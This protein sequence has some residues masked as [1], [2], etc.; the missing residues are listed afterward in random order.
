M[1]RK[2]AELQADQVED[3]VMNSLPTLSATEL[4]EICTLIGVV[5][6]EDDK[7]KKRVLLK[8][9]MKNL[10]DVTAT[11]DK[12]TEFLQIFKHLKL[13]DTEDNTENGDKQGIKQEG[14]EAAA[15]A[16]V[17]QNTVESKPEK[18]GK[19]AGSGSGKADGTVT[20]TRT[21]RKDFKL[22]G[23][24]G[25]EGES[26]LTYSGLKFEI[27]KARKLGHSETEICSTVISKVADKELRCYFETEA[28]MELDE[29]LC[30][31]KSVCR[32][33]KSSSVFTQFTN[34]KQA[35]N[36]KAITFITRVL[37][38]RKRVLKLGKEEGKTYDEEML[39]ERSFE[40]IFGGLRS[41]NIR[42]AL[43]DKCRNDHALPDKK[44]LAHAADVIDAE[45]ERKLKLFGKAVESETDDVEVSEMMSEFSREGG[46]T[47]SVRFDEQQIKKEKKNKIN[48]FTEIDELR[49]QIKD[50]DDRVTAQ[51][52]EI[53]QLVLKKNEGDKPETKTTGKEKRKC[54][55]CVSENRFWCRHCWECGSDDHKR[56]D[57]PENH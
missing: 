15:A 36:E 38:L 34:D 46:A 26:A 22:S 9:V 53:K 44:V 51:L 45:K 18:G 41:D 57:C 40:V 49:C 47:R 23:M 30:M 35:S 33:Q 12:M 6:T 28:D 25:G 37:R 8:L 29:V 55:K 3:D 20:V 27:E 54:P 52:N 2:M 13:D 48:P 11:D 5:M 1:I 24:I 42:S 19:S 17:V 43:R 56:P 39:A 31:L 16:S 4:E 10:C 21:I 32:E 50:N 7:G 14:P